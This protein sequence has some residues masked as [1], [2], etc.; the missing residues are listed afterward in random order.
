MRIV[1]TDVTE[2]EP[3]PQQHE[4][5]SFPQVTVTPHMAWYS[6]ESY[7]ELKRR[8]VENVAR[9]LIGAEP[10]TGAEFVTDV[11]T[12]AF[13]A[14]VKPLVEKSINNPVRQALFDAVQKANAAHPAK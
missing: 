10:T 8:T 3:L 5:L 14:R 12:A 1:I 6:E 9:I 7:G 4:L 13:K 2:V 11:D